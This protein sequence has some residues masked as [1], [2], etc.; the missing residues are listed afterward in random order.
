MCELSLRVH[1][2]LV[3]GGRGGER[4]GVGERSPHAHLALGSE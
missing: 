3:I 2:P 4:G 1:Q